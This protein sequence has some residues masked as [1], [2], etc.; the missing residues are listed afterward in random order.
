MGEAKRKKADLAPL[1]EAATRVGAALRKLA[2]AASGSF[3]G[4]CYL[5][6]EL[7]RQLM[8]D[9]GFNCERKTGYA[10]WRVGPGDGDVISHT[11][12]AQGYLPP[13]AQGFAYH[14]WLEV[15]GHILDFTTYQLKRKAA[16]LDAMDGGHTQ[17]AWCPDFLLI[18]KHSLRTY[19][20]VAQAPTAPAIFYEARSNVDDFLAKQFTLDADDVATARLLM[21]NPEMM[22]M[23]PNDMGDA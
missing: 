1:T 23:G 13:G 4:D 20:Q 3:G 14:T 15:S 10:A 19:R 11:D 22:V 21:A 12:Q 17:V 8:A 5:H 2:T 18:N 16:E 7:G 6:A 9:L